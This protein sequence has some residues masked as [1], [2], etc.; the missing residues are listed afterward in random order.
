M[1]SFNS[2][3]QQEKIFFNT[4]LRLVVKNKNKLLYVYSQK[5]FSLCYFL[6]SMDRGGAKVRAAGK[7]A[8]EKS[9]QG[10]QVKLLNTTCKKIALTLDL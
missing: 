10:E 3:E 6:F 5:L 8:S 2:E 9:C 1:A 7:V 4:R